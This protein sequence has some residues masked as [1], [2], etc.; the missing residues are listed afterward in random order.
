MFHHLLQR[1][2]KAESIQTSHVAAHLPDK[3]KVTQQ[4]D[5]GMTELCHVTWQKEIC[6]TLAISWLSL[7]LWTWPS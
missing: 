2:E 1:D 6:I 7:S 3:C 5:E 4:T